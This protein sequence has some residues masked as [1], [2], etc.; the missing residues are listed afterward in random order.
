MFISADFTVRLKYYKFPLL[1]NSVAEVFTGPTSA[2]LK[3]EILS[4]FSPKDTSLRIVIATVAFGMG[5]DYPDIRQVIH[6]GV[7]TS[8][9]DLVQQTGRAGRDGQ[10]AKSIVIRNALLPRTSATIKAFAQDDIKDC[11]RKAL[12]TPFYGVAE[13]K[14]PSPLCTCCDHCARVCECGNCDIHCNDFM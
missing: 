13:V 9:E 14:S 7:P 1:Q 6:F 4:S 10:L 2:P 11:R 3:E 5:I 12:F 8:A